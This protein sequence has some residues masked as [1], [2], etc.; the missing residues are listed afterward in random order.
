LNNNT[1]IEFQTIH[2]YNLGTGEYDPNC[3][4]DTIYGSK[5]LYQDVKNVNNI[6]HIEEKFAKLENDASR[7]I[8]SI[9][10][11][12]DRG[13]MTVSIT[14]KD[15]YTLQ[16]FLFLQSL[17][18]EKISK[19]YFA[20]DHPSNASFRD[21]IKKQKE[22]HDMPSDTYLWLNA[23][24]YY[25]E[26]PTRQILHDFDSHF[27]DMLSDPL[28]MKKV[29]ERD[30]DLDLK[31]WHA[32]T[33]AR[34]HNDHFLSICYASKDGEFAL[35]HNSFGLWEGT[36]LGSH[37]HLLYIISPKIAIVMRRNV[38]KSMPRSM[39]I[40]ILNDIP[41]KLPAA[42]Y[43][44]PINVTPNANSLQQHIKS[45]A[46]DDDRFTFKIHELSYIQTY[47]VNEIVLENIHEDGVL[48]FASEKI[49]LKTLEEYDSPDGSFDK[50]HRMS[51]LRTLKEILLERTQ[52]QLD[53][54]QTS[55]T[56]APSTRVATP[57]I[58]RPS[59]S[60]NSIPTNIPPEMV[61]VG[62]TGSQGE[63]KVETEPLD[64][65]KLH[66]V[67]PKAF[68]K[69]DEHL[70]N[71]NSN[72]GKWFNAQTAALVVG[73]AVVAGSAILRRRWP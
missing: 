73:A 16:K 59:R 45:D 32:I 38:S 62:S 60:P 63:I 48:V 6:N 5:N 29:F 64:K 22:I 68:K 40:S 37:A 42:I 13:M 25:L 10:K 58:D 53:H 28:A 72:G 11:E 9:Q 17:R 21:W 30:F 47:R 65:T 33:Y 8:K 27:K 41:F 14:Q 67:N 46:A 70:P 43:A 71:N 18:S 57:T 23:I 26:T 44:C 2:S 49:M 54:T 36:I 24:Q 69:D 20:E 51:P 61:T 55:S 12:A 31:Q 7:V 1:Q 35:G 19:T 52:V 66:N 4:I 34:F 15:V 3:R 50:P 56:T 39:V